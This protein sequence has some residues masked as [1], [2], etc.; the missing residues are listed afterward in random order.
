VKLRLGRRS[1]RAFSLV[2]LLVVLGI[3]ALLVGILMPAL[4]R[5]RQQAQSVACRANLQ[6]IGQSLLIYAND[7]GGWMFPPSNGP[8]D[9]R[10]KEQYW[11]CLV[12]KPPVWNP[13]VLR[14]PADV[15]PVLECSYTLNKYLKAYQIRYH[16]KNLGSKNSSTV[17]VMGEK[18]SNVE[19]YYLDPG[20]Y[21]LVVEPFRHGLSLKSNYLYL[22][23]HVDNQAETRVIDGFE[24]WNIPGA[25]R[26]TTQP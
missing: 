8:L 25:T 6:Q 16:S 26:P 13:P 4:H 12:F 10:P 5:A 9:G 15:D 21:D 23:L 24:P 14:C 22:D 18:R 7:N 11:P 3:I 20:E 1:F 2:E 19:G 17:I